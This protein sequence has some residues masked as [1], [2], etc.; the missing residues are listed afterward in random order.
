MPRYAAGHNLAD[1][2]LLASAHIALAVAIPKRMLR[3]IS[4]SNVDRQILRAG[5]AFPLLSAAA[6]LAYATFATVALLLSTC[7]IAFSFAPGRVSDQTYLSLPHVLGAPPAAG[8]RSIIRPAQCS[9]DPDSRLGT[10]IPPGAAHARTR[11]RASRSFGPEPKVYTFPISLRTCAASFVDCVVYIIYY[12]YAAR[13]G[14]FVMEVQIQAP[15]KRAQHLLLFSLFTTY[16]M[17]LTLH[18]SQISGGTFNH[19]AG[20]MSQVV[21]WHPAQSAAPVADEAG[22]QGLLPPISAT[23]ARQASNEPKRQPGI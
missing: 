1:H 4:L 17:P 14:A 15:R 7:V 13:D 20:N 8:S 22:Q 16:P 12:V 21:H 18:G 3:E 6:A 2:F 11:G 23:N 10:A 5:G 19:V 9:P